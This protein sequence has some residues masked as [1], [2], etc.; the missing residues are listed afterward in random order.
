[1]ENNIGDPYQRILVDSA[2]I[3]VEKIIT[4]ENGSK[5]VRI[6]I[7]PQSME[8]VR[9]KMEKIRAVGPHYN[10]VD[11]KFLSPEKTLFPPPEVGENWR[12]KII[13]KG[14]VVIALPLEKIS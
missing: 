11:G 2:S 1:M 6:V 5:T 12:V 13:C 3:S 9:G 7:D 8:I 4:K 10:W 14:D